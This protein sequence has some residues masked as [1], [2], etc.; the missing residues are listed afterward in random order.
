M[1]SCLGLQFERYGGDAPGREHVRAATRQANAVASTT[2]SIC[3][4]SSRPSP[5][6]LHHARKPPP[7]ASPAPIVSTTLARGAGTAT[8]AVR[9][10]NQRPVG[11]AR[12]QPDARAVLEQRAHALDAGAVRLEELEV[13]LADLEHVRVPEHAA[14]PRAVGVGVGD[15]PG[16]AVR[17]DRDQGAVRRARSTTA[18]R[19]L[20]HR[21]Q[22]QPERA[23][24]QDV[25]LRRQRVE[26][27]LGR[28]PRR[29]GAALV[30]AVARRRRRGRPRRARASWGPRCAPR[31]RDRRRRRRAASRSRWPKRS[32]DRR[33]R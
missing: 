2:R 1:R 6:S 29:R 9:R 13:L 23:D 20:R 12:E 26:R 15:H 25:D 11:P 33:P 24:V 18:S 31:S 3:P 22:C 14:D 21:L 7:N 32:V 19:A 17:I 8:S 28:Q 5:R 10:D 4:S 30:E 16:P 27:G